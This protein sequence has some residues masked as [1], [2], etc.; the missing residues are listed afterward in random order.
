MNNSINVFIIE[1]EP[2]ILDAYKSALEYLSKSTYN[3]DVKT[4]IAKSYNEALTVIN[5]T[6]NHIDFDMVMLNIN[7]PLSNNEKPI[8]AEDIGL[9]IR[10]LLPEVKFI[11]FS[12]LCDNYRI[13]N[14]LN[15][16]NPEGFFIKSDV[17]YE[18]LK[19]AVHLVLSENLYYSKIV[20]RFIRRH[21]FN[22]IVLDKV[23]R[24]LLYF[25]SR[26]IKTKDLSDYI[27]LSHGGI[28]RRKRRLKELFEI[29]DRSD[30]MLLKIAQEK[31][32]I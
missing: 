25:L 31:G 16:L 23:D 21:F 12:S 7:I 28:Q 9:K 27:C 10:A 2:L 32:F 4:K 30:M 3:F 11:I 8:F 24:Q 19:K 17:N 26:G 18:E 29:E 15:I 1:N 20:L 6:H 13:N 22:D 5:E 14:I